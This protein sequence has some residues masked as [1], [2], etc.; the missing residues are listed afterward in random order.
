MLLCHRRPRPP[1]VQ[2]APQGRQTPKDINGRGERT[3]RTATGSAISRSCVLS[4]IAPITPPKPDRDKCALCGAV[5]SVPP[6]TDFAQQ[7]TKLQ[8]RIAVLI[9]STALRIQLTEVGA[10]L[11]GEERQISPIG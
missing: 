3:K 1:C 8:A 10:F 11:G 2:P 5:A 7:G 9:G 4:T 6:E